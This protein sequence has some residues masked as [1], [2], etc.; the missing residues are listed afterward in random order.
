MLKLRK[1]LES[2]NSFIDKY[3]DV[4]E[5]MRR[6]WDSGKQHQSWRLVP[7]RLLELVWLTF[8]KYGRVHEEGLEK[9]WEIVNENIIKIG[10]NTDIREGHDLEIFG[11]ENYDEVTEE[12]WARFF[13]FISDRGK[14]IGYGRGGDWDVK[15]GHARYS[16]GAKGLMRMADAVEAAKNPE[17]KLVA[18]DQIL[19]FIHGIG[20]MAKWFVEGGVDS[21]VDLRDKNVKGIHLVGRLSESRF[22]AIKTKSG[23][24]YIGRIHADAVSKT[25]EDLESV[26]WWEDGQYYTEDE[27]RRKWGK[28][29]T[30]DLEPGLHRAWRLH[31]QV[32]EIPDTPVNEN[33][34]YRG[35]NDSGKRIEEPFTVAKKLNATFA[36]ENPHHAKLYGHRITKFIAKPE[37]KIL[38]YDSP[39]F[40]RLLKRRRPPNSWIGS[41]TKAGEKLVDIVNYLTAIAYK[42]R[43]DAVV[44]SPTDD[45]GTMIFN[46][47]A[48]EVSPAEL[49]ESGM[50]G[51][52]FIVVD[53][54]PEYQKFIGFIPRLVEFLNESYEGFGN[55]VFLY[56][57]ADTLGMV[58]ESDYK[59][60]W[61]ENG[62]E[63]SVMDGSY[64][65]DK[66]YAFFRYC[67]DSG[68]LGEGVIANFVRF[69]YENN[70]RDS[71]DMTRDMWA[72]Y[73]REYR[74]T[75]RKEVFEL[76]H[77]AG[78]CVHVPDLMDYLKRFNNIVVC[79][80]GV[81]ECLKEVEIALQA[82]RK[83][84][85]VE[86]RFTY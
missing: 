86:H 73:L 55:L 77:R 27:A 84:Y 26:G 63:E 82:L 40:W 76:L 23:K 66:G 19:N 39:E 20:Y 57:G 58:N 6:E 78:D 12:E 45:I 8:V 18:I 80:G 48:F 5:E 3:Y 51:K 64:F 10:I 85:D 56:N 13:N 81:T 65:Y 24:V 52:T 29:S 33:I 79:G 36:S 50:S 35:E 59:M 70:V 4:K 74:R 11:K 25:E 68:G 30:D 72:K 46:K 2:D 37:A 17:E 71:R 31:Q 1:L 75:D 34:F 22:P 47:G 16:D 38:R 43:Y 61:F 9:I 49:K 53:V 7:K 44:F 69:M 32:P 60:W 62:L 15:K 42:Q 28:A 83:P 67:M 41:A 54:Q 21:L 14:K